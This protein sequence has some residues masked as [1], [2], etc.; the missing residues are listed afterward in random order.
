MRKFFTKGLTVKLDQELK[1]V[2]LV[3]SLGNQHLVG[4][5][6]KLDWLAWCQYNG[7]GCKYN[8][9]GCQYNGTGWGGVYGVCGVKLRR[10]S[11]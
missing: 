2:L 4:R 7:T 6:R 10:L 11:Q 5:S 3:A 8:G 1:V 9:T